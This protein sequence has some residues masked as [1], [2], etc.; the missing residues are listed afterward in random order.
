MTN[1]GGW[2]THE[3]GVRDSGQGDKEGG[4][5]WEG[6]QG[7]QPLHAEVAACQCHSLQTRGHFTQ[8]A[9]LGEAI[10]GCW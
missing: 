9:V 6:Q 8:P 10:Q 1:E 2:E 4:G 3:L 7:S 5:V